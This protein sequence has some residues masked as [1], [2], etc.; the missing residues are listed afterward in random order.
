LHIPRRKKPKVIPH[1]QEL[2]SVRKISPVLSLWVLTALA[3]AQVPQSSHV[4]VVVEE[5]HGYSSVVGSSA[6]PYFNS[7][8]SQNVLFTQYYANTH[9]SIGNYLMMTTGQIITN[10]DGY[11]G[12]VTADNIVRHMLTAGKTWKSYAESLP[13]VGYTG[14]DTGLYVR[15]HNPFTYF[16]DVLNSSVQKLNLVPFTQ[17][18]TDLSNNQLPDFSFVVPNLNDDAHNGTLSQADN[19]LKT[20]IAPLL[21]NSG[22]QKDGILVVI[23]DEGASTDTTHGGGHIAALMVGPG[24]KKQ[25]KSGTLYQH[26]SI[27]R[28]VMSALGMTSYPGAA[29][30]AVSMT[31]AFTAATSPSPSPTPTPTPSP[32]PT[33]TPSP[34]SCTATITGIAVCSPAS[35]STMNSPVRFTA[36]AKSSLPITAMRIYIDS[37]SAYFTNAATLDVS[38]AVS[39]GTHNVVVQAWNSGGSVFKTPL[40]ITVGGTSAACTAGTAGVTV[41]APSAGSTDGSPVHVTAAAKSSRG[42]ITA[43]RIYV[44]GVS[45]YRTTAADLATS[46]SMASGSHNVIVQA[47]DS[48]GSVYKNA[49]TISVP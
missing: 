27:L 41:C 40:T 5:N 38:L 14:G 25:F 28:T 15:H 3:V 45:M 31:D 9:P 23:F 46:V 49:R 42:P 26:Q 6:M 24:V 39:I 12:T 32:S 13:S 43:M 4:V 1:Y 17:F 7:L 34:S 19:W 8:A 20:H 48:T 30:T 47:W 44:D 18:A 16:S 29:A 35:G 11:T 37:V 36:A 22:F 21:S 10:S 33:P 2:F